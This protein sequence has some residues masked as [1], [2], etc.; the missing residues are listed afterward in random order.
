MNYL[1]WLYDLYLRVHVA[2]D[3][4]RSL[5]RTTQ[6]RDGWRKED[7]GDQK[8]VQTESGSAWAQNRAPRQPRRHPA[9]ARIATLSVLGSCTENTLVPR[10]RKEILRNRPPIVSGSSAFGVGFDVVFVAWHVT[11][12]RIWKPGQC[13]TILTIAGQIGISF[14]ERRRIRTTHSD[15]SQSNLTLPFESFFFLIWTIVISFQTDV[16]LSSF[17]LG[18]K[19]Y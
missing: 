19:N 11:A 1:H 16:Y 8:D 3:L 9:F 7:G 6:F 14:L 15:E 10:Q 13:L 18:I 17:L 4:N 12:S 5:Q 2:K